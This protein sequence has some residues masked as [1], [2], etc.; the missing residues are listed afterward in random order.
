MIFL[1][2]LFIG[3]PIMVWLAYFISNSVY[4]SIKE[5]NKYAKLICVL[6]ALGIF[7][8]LMLLA[9]YFIVENIRL[10]R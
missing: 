2:F 7:A 5:T 8:V 6:L 4:K 1:P 3:I 10:E 9:F